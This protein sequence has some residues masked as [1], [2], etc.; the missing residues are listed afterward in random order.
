MCQPLDLT[1]LDKHFGNVS[2]WQAAVD[3]IHSRGMYVLLDNT[4]ATYVD[5]LTPSRLNSLGN[6]SPVVGSVT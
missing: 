5:T 2:M 4:M 1:L 3:E 6:F